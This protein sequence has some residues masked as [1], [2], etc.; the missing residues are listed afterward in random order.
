MKQVAIKSLPYLPEHNIPYRFPIR[1]VQGGNEN[2][3]LFWDKEGN[4]YDELLM[5]ATLF[6]FDG[7]YVF[8]IGMDIGGISKAAY[9][10]IF[11]QLCKVTDCLTR[12]T[13]IINS[14]HTH[15]GPW[16]EK[17]FGKNKN[18]LDTSNLH[19]E[20]TEHVASV[21]LRLFDL[22]KAD[23]KEFDTEISVTTTEGVYSNRNALDKS[24]DK[25][26][27][28]IRFKEKNSDNLIGM[29]MQLSCHSTIIF[30]KN[31]K[32]SSD[33][34]GNVRDLLS[35]HFQCP[36]MPMVGAAGD[37]STRLTRQR[38]DS[39]ELD[40]EELKRLSNLAYEQVIGNSNFKSIN[41]DRFEVEKVE[42]AYHYSL[43]HDRMKQRLVELDKQIENETN[44]QQLRLLVQSKEGL[45]QKINEPTD[46]SDTLVGRAWNLG[47]LKFGVFPG[48]LV[49]SL[50]KKIIQYNDNDIHLVLCYLE[51]SV[52]YLV[53]IEE[54]GKN[55]E[56]ITSNIPVG[57]PE[58]LVEMIRKK[59]EEFSY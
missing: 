50:G 30:P 46:A 19:M 4:C 37:T 53:E 43:N 24:C 40:Y 36:V 58:V 38:G 33:L 29:W 45:K 13:F 23:L 5:S 16:M 39:I 17:N 27:N 20:F 41:I 32:L 51:E 34:V 8:W 57:L 52:G 14:T 18:S 15:S 22:C 21:A 2:A 10:Y 44:S 26:I 31:P 56:S 47:D 6:N 54:Y 1:H 3:K 28:L 35:A 59:L 49:S 12:D 25:N 7:K 48:E 9:E 42:L 11:N 55:F